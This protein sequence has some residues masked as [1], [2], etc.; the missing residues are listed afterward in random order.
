MATNYDMERMIARV[1]P[2]SMKHIQQLIMDC[3]HCHD[4][5]GKKNWLGRDK[6]EKSIDHLF[7]TIGI[8]AHSI[9]ADG[10]PIDKS[11]ALSALKE[12][13]SALLLCELAYENWPHAFIFWKDWYAQ[14]VAKARR[15]GQ[16][17]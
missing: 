5:Y 1:Y 13:N 3:E 12:V 17:P 4:S 7:K 10:H 11:D 8:L 2:R 6:F 16:A 9:E 15:D 14:V